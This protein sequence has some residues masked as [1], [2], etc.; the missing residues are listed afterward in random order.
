ML[1]ELDCDV[2]ELIFVVLSS[3]LNE[4]ISLNRVIPKAK[5]SASNTF[6]LLSC[7]PVV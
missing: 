6:Q 4:L 3:S 1:L 2:F 7:D 5:I